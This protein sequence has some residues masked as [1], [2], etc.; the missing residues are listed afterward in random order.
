MQVHSQVLHGLQ[1]QISSYLPTAMLQ[2]DLRAHFTKKKSWFLITQHAKVDRIRQLQ[3]SL[4]SPQLHNRASRQPHTSCCWSRPLF[5]YLICS[6]SKLHLLCSQDDVP[7]YIHSTQPTW[8]WCPLMSS[9]AIQEPPNHIAPIQKDIH[10]GILPPWSGGN[11]IP[12]QE[13]SFIAFLVQVKKLAAHC[14]KA[15]EGAPLFIMFSAITGK[16]NWVCHKYRG[17]ILK[18]CFIYSPGLVFLEQVT[19]IEH[20]RDAASSHE[21]AST[22]FQISPP[23][24]RSFIS[25]EK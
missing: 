7:F 10:S 18:S 4:Q 14:S 9:E 12:V 2:N 22:F 13:T 3:F 24:W 20:W 8:C 15:G 17:E 6:Y 21:A 1:L 5:M 19:S 11:R 25:W 16:L 23:Q